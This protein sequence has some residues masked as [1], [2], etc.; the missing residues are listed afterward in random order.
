MLVSRGYY[1]TPDKVG[2]AIQAD[3]AAVGIEAE[4]VTYD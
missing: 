4:I 2:E 3:L 1:P